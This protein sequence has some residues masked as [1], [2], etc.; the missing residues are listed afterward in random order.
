MNKPG[1]ALLAALLLAGAAHAEPSPAQA[2]FDARDITA[3]ETLSRGAATPGDRQLALGA[4]LALRHKDQAAIEALLPLGRTDADADTRAKSFLALAD[5]YLRQ[6]RFADTAA[7][8]EQAK[9]LSSAPLDAPTLQTLDFAETAGAERPMRVARAA[10][11]SLDVTR[12]LAGLI[13]VPVQIGEGTQDVVIDS[14]AGFSTIAESAAKRLGLRVLQRATSVGS[15][16]KDSLPTRIGI[17]ARLR[18]GK[19]EL[20]D[21]V[22]IVM[23]DEALTFADGRYKIDAILGLPVFVALGR[24]EVANEAG[25]ESLYYGPKAD[26]GGE[27]DMLLAGL[28][29]LALVTAGSEAA[30]L[31]LLIDTGA[32]TSELNAKAIRDFPSLATAAVAHEADFQSAGGRKI[33]DKAM[34]IPELRLSIAGRAVTLKDVDLFSTAAVDR[35]GAIGQDVLKQ[36]G[37]FVL[38][39]DAMRF[40]LG[41]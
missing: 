4:A 7:V 16:S 21:V 5:I 10:S 39:F 36:G 33:D 8:L 26:A 2:A 1:S 17:A 14:G 6:G 27:P 28:Q 23:P 19:A 41:D 32:K 34:E 15:A 30:P 11:G 35:H 24:I 20:T 37:R 25:K 9:A 3:L 22:F 38:D 40:S 31:R 12:D 29:P 18:F 13:R